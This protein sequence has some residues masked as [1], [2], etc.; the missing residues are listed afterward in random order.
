MH[1]GGIVPRSLTPQPDTTL[2]E[3]RALAFFRHKTVAEL[4]Q[5]RRTR[6]HW[7]DYV[8]QAA[9]QEPAIRYGVVALGSVHEEFETSTAA[10]HSRYTPFE[11]LSDSHMAMKHYNEATAMV[12]GTRVWRHRETPLL[13][14][15]ILAAFDS[16]RGRPEPALYHRCN[17]LRILRELDRRL[18]S[19]MSELLVCIFVDFDTENLE[20]GQPNF[21]SPSDCH[22]SSAFLAEPL[23]EV[24]GIQSAIEAFELLFNRL[25]KASQQD[26]RV[27]NPGIG[28]SQR[29]PDVLLQYEEWCLALDAYLQA[30]VCN[31]EIMAD[32]DSYGDL[33]I[34]QMRRLM[35]KIL[36][37]VDL[38]HDDMDFDR[39][40]A[41]FACI[42]HLAE[43]FT[44]GCIMPDQQRTISLTAR[45]TR[46][47]HA[48]L[49][50]RPR[51]LSDYTGP[52]QSFLGIRSDRTPVM[53]WGTIDDAILHTSQLVLARL[54]RAQSYGPRDGTYARSRFSLAPGIILPLFITASNCRNPGI[55]RGALR[56]LESKHRKEGQWD[57]MVCAANVR[58]AIAAEEVRALELAKLGA[59][60]PDIELLEGSIR[61]SW[62]VPDAARLRG[63]DCFFN[64]DLL[65]EK[66]NR[67][68]FEWYA[69]GKDWNVAVPGCTTQ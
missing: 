50:R 35:V 64:E 53:K 55:R 32:D 31:L 23:R 58:V 56:L 42:V 34:L 54:P 57:S 39:F 44:N 38:R 68:R 9:E 8:L 6:Y 17:G 62:Q 10:F 22:F 7:L 48:T 65:D 4:S 11:P 12:L 29:L 40:E 41:E 45:P 60:S 26:L 21:T 63:F 52:R 66:K 19:S 24:T 69:T 27:S 20:L 43:V 36:L 61:E 47:D 25:L 5:R 16:L 3:K 14:S 33:V 46:A 13:A 30:C 1:N 28:P 2:D 15:L 49:H 51:C 67:K 59:E 37:N 18:D